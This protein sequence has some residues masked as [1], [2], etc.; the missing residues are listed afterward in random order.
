MSNQ[1]WFCKKCNSYVDAKS[2]T[3]EETHD[4]CGNVVFIEETKAAK[5][6]KLFYPNSDIVG[7]GVDVAPAFREGFVQ[8]FN[9]NK[10]ACFLE[11]LKEV[12]EFLKTVQSPRTSAVLL[13]R[14]IE[15]LI[16]I[17]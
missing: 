10:S 2:V 9:F 11:K 17:N 4:L 7:D 6:A 15:D 3:F 12:I 14:E 5:I 16:K 1:D 8:G 13:S